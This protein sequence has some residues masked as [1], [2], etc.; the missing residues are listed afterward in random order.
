M[1]P[2]KLVARSCCAA[3]AP[4][5]KA[6]ACRRGARRASGSMSL[7]KE[8]HRPPSGPPRLNAVASV[9]GG[10]FV[11]VC[12]R[13]SASDSLSAPRWPKS[14][15]FSLAPAAA[16]GCAPKRLRVQRA[17]NGRR[18]RRTRWVAVQVLGRLQCRRFDRGTLSPRVGPV[19]DFPRWSTGSLV[20]LLDG[21]LAGRVVAPVQT[22]S[23]E[24][25]NAS[26]HYLSSGPHRRLRRTQC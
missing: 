16:T 24:A 13:E 4:P 1:R 7:S 21:A 2:D 8:A 3:A 26:D 11:F 19:K 6:P 20:F 18:W 23:L 9:D 17:S 15:H 10:C 22:P 25:S 5:P 14:A 12:R